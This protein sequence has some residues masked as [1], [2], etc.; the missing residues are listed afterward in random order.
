[1][2][3]FTVKELI[4][5]AHFDHVGP[6]FPLWLNIKDLA[7]TLPNLQDV[8]NSLRNGSPY[9]MTL[10]L[11]DNNGNVYELPN[12]PL[13][14]LSRTKRIKETAV[15]GGKRRG[16]VK[17]YITTND[18]Q[19]TIRGVCVDLNNKNKYPGAQVKTLVALD[20]LNEALAIIPDNLFIAQFGIGKIVI[21]SVAYDE[22]LGEPGMQRYVIK[23]ISDED[24]FADL[25]SKRKI[26]S[27]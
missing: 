19:L 18:Y 13:I 27:L 25:N 12:E 4:Q 1:M 15:L 7:P 21:K 10:K 14:S 5:K 8:S 22:M 23:A 17:E 6:A 26:N 11:R 16:T 20:D 24:F 3:D 2:A 9:F